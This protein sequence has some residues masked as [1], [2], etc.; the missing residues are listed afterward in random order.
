MTVSELGIKHRKPTTGDSRRFN[1]FSRAVIPIAQMA[2]D[3]FI[4]PFLSLSSLGFAIFARHHDGVNFYLY[5][6]P[7]IAATMLLILSLAHSGVYDVFNTTS[8]LEV[9]KSTIGSL[10]QVMLLLTGCFFLLK[11][12]DDFSR[13][14]LITWSLTSAIGLCGARLVSTAAVKTLMRSGRLTKNIAVVGASEVGQRLAAKLAREGPD[15]RLAGLFDERQPSRVIRTAGGDA[16]VLPLSALDQML[17]AG[18]VDEVVIALHPSAS[19]RVLDLSRLFHPFA[20]ALRVLA[21]EGYEHFRV[22]DS[23][24]YGDISTFRVLSKPLDDVAVVL[25]WLEDKIIASLCLLIVTPPMLVIALA[26]KLDSPGP[27]FFKQARLGANNR[28]FDLLKFRSMYVEHADPLG[29]QLTRPGDPRITRVGI[30]LRRTSM[31]EL[32][33]LL[34]VIRGD[35]SLVGPRPHALAANAAGVTYARAVSEYLIRHR[36]KPGIT[37]WAQVNGWR[38]E[39][40]KIEQIRR[41]VEHDLEYIDKWS[42]AFDFLILIKT[43]R[44]VITR[45]NAV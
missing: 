14:W 43:F 17:S 42:L 25:K 34:N 11:I 30:F 13:I 45:E 26:I 4:L 10:T 38:G 6:P 36:V 37:G 1:E 18:V 40:T 22:L 44:T 8:R 33:Q 29:R 31:D 7:T 32:P 5:A 35:M 24:R 39:T 23:C 19:D 28:S 27:V 41:R 21:P 3:A 20:V 12:S 15:L 9:L 2:A 16:P